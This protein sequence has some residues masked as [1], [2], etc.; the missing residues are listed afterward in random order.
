MFALLRGP[1]IHRK[2][3]RPVTAKKFGKDLVAQTMA[4]EVLM[5]S[6]AV[7]FYAALS[8]APIV[9]LFVTI[10]GWLGESTREQ[11]IAAVS[12]T[13]GERPA[14][15]IR[16]VATEADEETDGGGWSLAISLIVILFGASGV[17][18]ALQR[19]L[20]RVWNVKPDPGAGVRNFVR[21][22][23]IS[24]GMVVAIGFLLLVSMIATTV[25]AMIVPSSGWLWSLV[26]LAISVLVFVLLFAAIFKVLP[27]VRIGWREV[28]MGAAIT[29][30]MFAIGKHLIGLYLGN[31]GVAGPYGAAG[32]LL[33]LLVWVYYSAIIVFIGAE[34]TQILA[35]ETGTAIK[36][37]R[38]AVWA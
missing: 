13:V 4:D 3:R 11:M 10:T 24:L 14:E 36:P 16:T 30:V 28:W 2:E 19:G 17:M 22:R 15:I 20:N 32:S 33:V 18:A 9:L 1:L 8:L 23:L 35:R 38:H 6:A 25:V 12:R 29:A 31:T 5:R 37:D 7:A 26:T 21:I 27:D 34:A